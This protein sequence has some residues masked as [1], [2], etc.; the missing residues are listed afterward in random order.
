MGMADITI[1]GK[2]AERLQ[3]LAQDSHRSVEEILE[4]ALD[5]L[6]Q[7]E[8]DKLPPVGSLARMAWMARQRPIE[9]EATDIADRSRDILR[10]EYAAH[11]LKRRSTS[12]D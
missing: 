6:A 9:V 2:V 11:L 5:N 12:D 10:D 1:T 4:T 3:Q 7:Q 8:E